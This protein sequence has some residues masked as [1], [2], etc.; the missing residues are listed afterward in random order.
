M[1]SPNPPGGSMSHVVKKPIVILGIRYEPGD[2]IDF[3]DGPN[4]RRLVKNGFIEPERAIKEDRE[5]AISRKAMIRRG[6]L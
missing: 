1:P 5:K 3:A 4:P 2:V 6:L